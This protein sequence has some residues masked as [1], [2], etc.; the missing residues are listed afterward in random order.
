MAP[1]VILGFPWKLS[2]DMFSYGC[3]IF[4]LVYGK[5]LFSNESEWAFLASVCSIMGDFP[6]DL[7]MNC[8]NRAIYFDDDGQLIW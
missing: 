2:V 4:E 3:L 6:E 7:K 8:P 5:W 1:E